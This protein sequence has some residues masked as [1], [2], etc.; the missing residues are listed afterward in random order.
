VFTDLGVGAV[1]WLLAGLALSIFDPDDLIDVPGEQL[2]YP[3]IGLAAF[4]AIGTLVSWSLLAAAVVIAC[5]IASLFQR[6]WI[7]ALIMLGVAPFAS[8][9]ALFTGACWN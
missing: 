4:A 5:G 6:R 2:F 3:P 1:I 9:L 7:G 8:L